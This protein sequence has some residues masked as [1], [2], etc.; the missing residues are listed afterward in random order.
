MSSDY[1][2]VFIDGNGVSKNLEH[3][4]VFDE[5]VSTS[6]EFIIDFR[7]GEFYA[8]MAF[9]PRVT[10]IKLTQNSNGTITVK[11]TSM[12]AVIKGVGVCME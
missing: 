8:F 7:K 3:I 4:T 5:I 9:D 6:A 1:G 2:A 12:R 11:K 10:N